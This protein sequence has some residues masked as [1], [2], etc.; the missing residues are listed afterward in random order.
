MNSSIVTCAGVYSSFAHYNDSLFGLN[1]DTPDSLMLA[2][3]T[4]VDIKSYVNNGDTAVNVSFTYQS[5][6]S[7]LT[8]TI[9]AVM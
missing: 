1:D 9:R 4:L 6:A 3:D 5:N 2:T 8:N 7:P